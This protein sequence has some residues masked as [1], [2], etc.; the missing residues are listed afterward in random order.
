MKSHTKGL[1]EST[2]SFISS[3]SPG[4]GLVTL[5]IVP[6]G[7]DLVGLTLQEFLC[8]L[9]QYMFIENVPT[10]NKTIIATAGVMMSAAAIDAVRKATGT[11]TYC[12]FKDPVT[13]LLTL[14]HTFDSIRQVGPLLGFNSL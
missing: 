8:V 9:E 5:F 4:T 1:N 2:A 10:L 3:L 14:L 7:L 13:E 6:V 11:K 12:Y